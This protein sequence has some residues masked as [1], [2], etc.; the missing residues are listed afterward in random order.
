MAFVIEIP[1]ITS[2]I[3]GKTL[4]LVAG[5]VKAYNLDNLYSKKG[6]DEH[7]KVFI[8]IQNRVCTNLCVW[9]DGYVGELKVNSLSQLTE[10]ITDLFLSYNANLHLQSMQHLSQYSLKE[11]QF[12]Q[13]IGRCRMYAHLP[14]HMQAKHLTSTVWRYP[15]RCC[16]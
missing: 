8:G 11:Q 12:A 9:T 16:L 4:H 15:T 3:E 7:F 13:L 5:G 14:K 6:A 2:T 10:G 1:S